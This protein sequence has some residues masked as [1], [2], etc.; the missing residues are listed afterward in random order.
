MQNDFFPR[1]SNEQAYLAVYA[2]D[3]IHEFVAICVNRHSRIAMT[4]FHHNMFFD[5]HR[6]FGTCILSNERTACR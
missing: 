5:R 4:L 1:G 6:V 2:G 3:D